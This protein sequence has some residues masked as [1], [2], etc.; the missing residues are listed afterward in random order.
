MKIDRSQ[1]NGFVEFSKIFLLIYRTSPQYMEVRAYMCT[2]MCRKC[3]TLIV[4]EL[5]TRSSL[6]LVY[7]DRK[8]VQEGHVNWVLE[9]ASWHEVSWSGCAHRR[10]GVTRVA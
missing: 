5:N 10:W 2:R 3:L 9:L 7:G 6:V 1:K 8:N 4:M